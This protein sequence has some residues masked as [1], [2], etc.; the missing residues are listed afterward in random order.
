LCK[1]RFKNQDAEIKYKITNNKN[2]TQNK[3]INKV[4]DIDSNNNNIYTTKKSLEIPISD[5]ALDNLLIKKSSGSIITN[6][7]INNNININNLNIQEKYGQE[8]STNSNTNI[9]LDLNNLN[10]KTPDKYIKTNYGID[11]NFEK[12][13]NNKFKNINSNIEKFPSERERKI[14]ISNKRPENITISPEKSQSDVKVL[15]RHSGYSIY[16]MNNIS[17]NNISNSNHKKDYNFIDNV[18]IENKIYERSKNITKK[19]SL[20]NSNDNI[21][22]NNRQSNV[23]PY[24]FYEKGRE[25]ERDQNQNINNSNNNINNNNI[26]VKY[27]IISDF[28]NNNNNNLNNN[29]NNNNIKLKGKII[30]DT[31]ENENLKSFN[32]EDF[33]ILKQIGEGSFGKIYLVHDIYDNQFSM[34]KIIANDEIDVENFMQEYEM[35]NKLRHKNILRIHSICKRKLDYTTFALYILMEKA[36]TDWDKEIKARHSQKKFY[37]EKEIFNILRQ[38]TSALVFLQEKNISHR[39]IKP[40]NLLLF[41]EGIFKVADFGEAKKISIYETSKQLNTLRGTELYMSPLLFNGLRTGQ[42]DIKHNPY[43]SD[44]FS[45]GFCVLYA[46]CLNIHSLHDLRR[47]TDT[48]SLGIKLKKSL[49]G[50]SE[51]LY[52]VLINM[53]EIDENKRYDFIQLQEVLDYL[54]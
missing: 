50:Y 35:V 42:E 22:N 31:K 25:K 46:A 51:T 10:L 16:P 26:K 15:H 29:I 33:R 45:L 8:I 4:K 12:I 34:K 1:E 40:Q 7:I 18:S 27:P 19:D 44:V 38:L 5:E 17:N 52:D 30:Y 13:D 53:L 24:K 2:N 36:V 28:N 20:E 21:R 11:L 48:F 54:K 47:E 49:K 32:C 3:D 14:T 43:K 6:Y 39:D 9:N 37:S 41:S 23:S